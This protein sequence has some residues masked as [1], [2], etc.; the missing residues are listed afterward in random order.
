MDLEHTKT[1]RNRVSIACAILF[2]MTILAAI[3]GAVG[4]FRQ[5]INSFAMFPGGSLKLTGPMAPDTAG[6]NDMMA[7]T[8]TPEVAVSLL[9]TLQEYWFGMRMWRGE[10]TLSPNIAPGTYSVR[11]FGKKDQRIFEDNTFRVIVYSDRQAYLADSKS[12]ILSNTGTSP[13]TVTGYL[14]ICVFLGCVWLYVISRKQDRLMAEELGEA[15][16]YHVRRQPN[17]VY[18]YFGLG[19][20][21]GITKGAKL[22]STD[23]H[24]KRMEEA[25]VE[26]VSDTD[27]IARLGPLSNAHPGYIV[28][29]A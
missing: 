5:P 15:E 29:K 26:D 17:A 4:Y 22:L 28:K 14:L 3:D 25:V 18:I 19:L 10:I 8:D 27:A 20:R 12:I 2:C 9:E 21:N 7:Q 6:V 13:W 16:V 1:L 23:P 11:V 24:G